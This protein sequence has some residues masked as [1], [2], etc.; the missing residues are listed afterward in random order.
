MKLA[1]RPTGK[2]CNHC[3]KS[4]RSQDPV[5]PEFTLLW[6]RYERDNENVLVSIEEVSL[7]TTYCDCWYSIMQ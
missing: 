1:G 3:G 5:Q 6:G 4:D 2:V 7:K